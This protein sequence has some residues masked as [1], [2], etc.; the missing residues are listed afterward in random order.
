[1]VKFNYEEFSNNMT[2]QAKDVIPEDI[3][4]PNANYLIDTIRKFTLLAGEVIENDSEFNFSLDDKVFV[5]Q[6]LAEWTFHKCVDLARSDIP[7][8]YWDSIMQ[9]L[10]FTIYE[11]CRQGRHR[12]DVDKD[13]LLNA[14]EYHVNKVWVE[15]IDKLKNDNKI[16]NKCAKLAKTLSNIDD[17]AK[18]EQAKR[19]NC[20]DKKETKKEPILKK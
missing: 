18:L 8:K 6:V 1:M 19:N 16:D 9:K 5:I 20:K 15:C 7:N 10:A 14:V 11:I 4:P 12:E 3:S 17:M 13:A 2:Q